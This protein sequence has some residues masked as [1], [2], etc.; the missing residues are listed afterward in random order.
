METNFTSLFTEEEKQS[1]NYPIISQLLENS[2]NQIKKV[3]PN[4][5][6]EEATAYANASFGTGYDID[7][8]KHSLTMDMTKRTFD[9][10]IAPEIVGIQPMSGPIGLYYA[11]R[12]YADDTYDSGSNVELGYNRIDP[13]YSGSYAASASETLGSATS[14]DDGLGV[15]T[16]VQMKDVSIKVEKKQVEA[17]S[18]K[19]RARFTDELVQ[20]MEYMHNVNLKSQI[21]DGLARE[22]STEIDYEIINK[23][24]TIATSAAQ[25][26]FSAIAGDNKSD[27]Y[28]SFIPYVITQTNQ[29]GINTNHGVGNYV[30]CS[31]NISTVIE[32][33]AAFSVSTL[34]EGSN[35]KIYHAGKI[36]E[37]DVYRNIFW[38]TDKYIVGYKGDT[39]LDA[40][41]FFL[42]YTLVG[43]VSSGA[44]T[45][46]PNI[47]ILSRYALGESIFGADKYYRKV[48]VVNYI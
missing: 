5:T 12:F 19:M 9:R 44:S 14:P 32:S 13:N 36:N 2:F 21:I 31:P 38:N 37:I 23:I 30:I 8:M 48:E 3:N 4:F 29:I 40:G 1:K 39:Q 45:F 46:Q 27:K 28:N 16:G 34:K 17:M 41:I 22:I 26:D 10:L 42:P 11:M 20:D 6:L 25:L 43:L 47:G 35:S 18:R 15:G 33:T 7:G 24:E